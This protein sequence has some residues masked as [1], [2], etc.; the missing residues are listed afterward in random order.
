MFASIIPPL[1]NLC[2]H[3]L[4]GYFSDKD[5]VPNILDCLKS[6]DGVFELVPGF[7]LVAMAGSS[8]YFSAHNINADGLLLLAEKANSEG[9]YLFPQ[10]MTKETF[11]TSSFKLLVEDIAMRKKGVIAIPLPALVGKPRN[12]K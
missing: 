12:S 11:I 1:S 10:Y 6:D 7:Q 2:R 9:K 8:E 5:I 4:E 3:Y